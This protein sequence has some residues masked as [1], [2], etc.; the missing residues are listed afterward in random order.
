MIKGTYSNNEIEQKQQSNS[1]KPF[2]FYLNKGE[3]VL[4]MVLADEA[5][6]I[7]M[8]NIYKEPA[9]AGF[10]CV[11]LNDTDEASEDKPCPLCEVGNYVSEVAMFPVVS[12]GSIEDGVIVPF[13]SKK[14]VEIAPASAVMN[15]KIKPKA[16]NSL[17]SAV[18]LRLKK[19]AK[20][21]W[22]YTLI[23]VSRS[24]DDKAPASGDTFV[25]EDKFKPFKE[26]VEYIKENYDFVAL[27]VELPDNEPEKTWDWEDSL[28]VY[29]YNELLKVKPKTDIADGI[30]KPTAKVTQR[31]NED[32]KKETNNNDNEE[33]D[34]P[35]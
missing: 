20:T 13:V 23:A 17:K 29:T 25:V 5:F 19:K 10:D 7:R 27:S 16:F 34:L 8:H 21:G 14:N 1:N 26:A 35:F 9:L 28:T 24:H 2:N 33:E 31:R 3:R 32:I 22:K 4:I 15:W 11:C 6:K 30:K 18:E 12:F